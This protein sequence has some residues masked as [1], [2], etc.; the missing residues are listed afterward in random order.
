[1][2]F[3][4]S[5]STYGNAS[6]TASW[7]FCLNN[8]LSWYLSLW[9][10]FIK[11][12]FF[13]QTCFVLPCNKLDEDHICNCNLAYGAL[14]DFQLNISV[15]QITQRLYVS[16]SVTMFSYPKP[17]SFLRDPHFLI[18]KQQQKQETLLNQMTCDD[19]P[20]AREIWNR[21]ANAQKYR[22]LDK[23]INTLLTSF[24]RST[25]TVFYAD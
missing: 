17:N 8:L 11:T 9:E 13:R 15:V 5:S 21:V 7:L 1:M 4:E 6:K 23:N 14:D 25:D 10:N 3:S 12:C 18:T 24:L 22:V 20:C 2:S 16:H 19:S